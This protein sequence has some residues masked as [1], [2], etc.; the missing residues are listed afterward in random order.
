MTESIL[1]KI[2]L[3]MF[4]IGIL[5]LIIISDKT[6]IKEY[7]INK[8]SKDLIEKEI[9]ITGKISNLKET[10]DYII[11]N[12]TNDKN[13]IKSIIYKNKTSLKLKEGQ[14]VELTGKVKVYEKEF[15]IEAIEIKIL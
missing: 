12:I 13:S 9:K 4:L 3:I 5:I 10:K 2:T 8:I 7:P 14:K 15:E 11:V 6:K 1:I